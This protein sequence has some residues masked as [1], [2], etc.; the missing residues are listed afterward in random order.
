MVVHSLTL[1]TEDAM[2]GTVQTSSILLLVVA[3]LTAFPSQLAA[4]SNVIQLR[5]E[6]FEPL[7]SGYEVEFTLPDGARLRG[8]V[9]SVVA[10]SLMMKVEKTSDKSSYPKGR[11]TIPRSSI[12]S[13]DMT[14]RTIRGRVL[15]TTIGVGLGVLLG[16]AVVFGS[17]WERSCNQGAA[18]AAGLGV[19]FGIGALGH[20]LGR[21]ADT[22]VTTIRIVP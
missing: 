19:G 15:G 3:L 18:T 10:D 13:L 5:W 16:G 20:F 12:S 2:E 7:V 9:I 14:K 21:R 22:N 4:E 17:C 6:E 8:D 11:L 1:T